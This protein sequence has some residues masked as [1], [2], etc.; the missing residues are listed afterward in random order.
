MA[1]GATKRQI[2]ENARKLQQLRIAAALVN[3]LFVLLRLVLRYASTSKKTFVLY[4][5]SMVV[6]VM[7]QLQLEVMGR[8]S[9]GKTGNLLSAGEDLLQSGTIEYI[10][11]ILYLT[12]I[13]YIL[14]AFVTDY[15]WILYLSVIYASY[16]FTSLKIEDSWLCLFQAGSVATEC[17]GYGWW[18]ANAVQSK[19]RDF[20]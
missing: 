19:R 12:W 20:N 9:Y 7:L 15:A 8:A 4:V 13:I 1:Q 10:C 3:L 2:V 11:D 16:S 5:F 17:I 6:A 18:D 14:V